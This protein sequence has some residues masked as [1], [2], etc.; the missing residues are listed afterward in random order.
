MMFLWWSNLALGAPTVGAIVNPQAV[1]D[2]ASD[3]PGED[4]LSTHTWVR[5]FVRDETKRG[6]RWFV[7][8]WFQHHVLIGQNTGPQALDN[9]EAF[10][11]LAL[12][13]TGVDV[14][15]GGTASPARLRVG[16][17]VA[18]TGKLELLPVND[19]VNP[20][21]GRIGLLTPREYQR[22]PVPMATLKLS[23]GKLRSETTY[24]PFATPDRLWLRETDWS[25]LR[26][27]MFD[28]Y[29]ADLQGPVDLGPGEFPSG[30]GAASQ[31]RRFVQTLRSNQLRES[32][33]TSSRRGRD[34][35]TNVNNLPQAFVGDLVQQVT[36]AGSGFD[37]GVVGG[38]LRSRFPQ[39]VLREDLRQGLRDRQEL[40]QQIDE[41]LFGSAAERVERA[42]GV[43]E[44]ALT[45]SWP[46]TWLAGAHGSTVV[47]DVALR[48][49]VGYL[50]DRVVRQRWGRSRTLPQL[51]GGVGID[52]NRGT[53]F[54]LSLEGRVQR[55][56]ASESVGNSLVFA[57]P[58]QVQFAGGVR[59]T[60]ASERF[61]WQIAGA[62]DAT[63]AEAFVRPTIAW[64][65]TSSVEIEVGG[66]V[67][68]GFVDDAPVTLQ[69]ALTYPG[70]PLSF[71]QQNDGF[72]LGLRWIL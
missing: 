5:G 6:D 70:G 41:G 55:L 27:R 57:R 32:K 59:G 47:G 9:N 56:F 68:D 51:A 1:V 33:N 24:V 11:E 65:A 2:T 62:V 10:Y 64:R 52:V 31:W 40:F 3:R 30:F 42:E 67:I 26:Q 44:S 23:S 4:P 50:S 45:F 7:E 54:G 53:S 48:G 58:L 39:A 15:L 21:D 12:G 17:L 29:L 34:F 28:D 66:I 72:T 71:W 20:I 37:V 22:M 43:A 18:S 8:A 69:D 16:A 19:L 61:T 38:Y 35:A 46:Y 36:W 49:E 14:R 60:F 13:P 25:L 63:F